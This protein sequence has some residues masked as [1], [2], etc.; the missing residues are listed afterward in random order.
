MKV[1]DIDSW[2]RKKHCQVFARPDNPH[3]PIWAN[4]DACIFWDMH[5]EFRHSKRT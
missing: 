5:L 2:D 4:P 3:H 1:I